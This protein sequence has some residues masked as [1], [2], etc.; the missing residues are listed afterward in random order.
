MRPDAK[1][2]LVKKASKLPTDDLSRIAAL[3]RCGHL[4][5]FFGNAK[6][7]DAKTVEPLSEE[8]K[9]LAIE[10]LKN[11]L[12][13]DAEINVSSTSSGSGQNGAGQGAAPAANAAAAAALADGEEEKEN[14]EEGDA[15]DDESSTDAEPN[16]DKACDDSQMPVD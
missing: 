15:D 5:R 7:G 14:G 3:K 4:E 11:L 6:K 16:G 12:G 13:E 2:R 10:R 1:S 9:K 8:D